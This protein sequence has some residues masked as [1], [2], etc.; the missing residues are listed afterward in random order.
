MPACILRRVQTNCTVM[1][2][3]KGKASPHPAGLALARWTVLFMA[4]VWLGAQ[5]QR[6]GWSLASGVVPVALWWGMRLVFTNLHLSH[7]LPRYIPWVLGVLTALGTLAIANFPGLSTFALLALACVWA[8]WTAVLDLPDASSR[9]QGRWAGWPPLLAAALCALATVAPVPVAVSHSAVVLVLLCAAWL[10]RGLPCTRREAA[11][12]CGHPA[13][14]IPTAA[15]GLMMGTLWLGSD[16]CRSAGVSNA[17]LVVMHLG[18]MAAL[19]ALTRLDLIARQLTQRQSQRTSLLLVFAGSMVLVSGSQ[20]AHGL[21]GMGLMFLAWAMHAG[22]YGGVVDKGWPWSALI[23]PILLLLVGF[24]SPLVG[25]QALLWA[26]A[27]L[28][29]MALLAVPL[30]GR[31]AQPMQP[32]PFRWRDAL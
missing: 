31:Y 19:P 27:A 6:V 10:G 25:P 13:V 23:G 11:S 7:Y 26:Y 3:S 21:V 17:Q 24:L 2:M 16:W 30:S 1:R 9:C 32:M 5:G 15:M 12:H 29:I 20:A 18:V 22:R 8:A 28:G 4:W 14:V